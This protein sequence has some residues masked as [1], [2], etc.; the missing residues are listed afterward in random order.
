MILAV[1]LAVALA[2]FFWLVAMMNVISWATFE[3]VPK[4]YF[5]LLRTFG[6]GTACFMFGGLPAFLIR[7][8]CFLFR[9]VFGGFLPAASQAASLASFSVVFSRVS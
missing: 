4:L 8:L 3:A 9:F 2:Y 1:I 7:V 5:Y 6:G